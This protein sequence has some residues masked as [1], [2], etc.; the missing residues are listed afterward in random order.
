MNRS[1][2]PLPSVADFYAI[3]S[4]RAWLLSRIIV[5]LQPFWAP[6]DE[7]TDI[8]LTPTQRHLLGLTP[9]SAPPTPGSS[10]IT[11]PRY[12]RSTPRSSSSRAAVIGSSPLDRSNSG[13]P[14]SGSPLAGRGI[15]S[16]YGGSPF[17]TSPG[18]G[19]PLVRKAVEGRRWSSGASGLRE[20]LAKT[21]TSLFDESKT[22]S[23]S[24][25]TSSS[26]GGGQRGATVALNSKWLYQRNKSR[27]SGGAFN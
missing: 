17:G 20:S 24:L 7:L 22:T 18:G 8:P 27:L 19:S 6:K 4:I 12:S 3:W 16:P 1:L 25:P 5:S 23:P 26:P 13:S 2:L 21:E 9:S 11:P 15:G 10:Y 14:I